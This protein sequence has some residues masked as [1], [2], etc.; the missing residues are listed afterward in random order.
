[1]IVANL[2]KDSNNFSFCMRNS[3]PCLKL[4]NSQQHPEWLASSPSN[5]DRLEITE[6]QLKW[7]AWSAHDREVAG[8]IPA[9]SKL[10]YRT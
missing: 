1:M 2:R 4:P 7:F 6:V 9:A 5:W 3:N 10:F 8:S